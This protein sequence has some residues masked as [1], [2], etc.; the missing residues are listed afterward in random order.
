MDTPVTQAPVQ[1]AVVVLPPFN[2]RTLTDVVLDHPPPGAW[3]KFLQ[4]K[5]DRVRWA[6]IK[7]NE[8][9]PYYYPAPCDVFNAF[10][11]TPLETTRVVIIGQDPYHSPRSRYDVTR[12]R[13]GLA[14]GLSFSVPRGEDLP[15]SLVNIYKELHSDLGIKPA[16]HG[17]LTA[18]ASQGVLL[19]NT[20]LTVEPGEADSH[21]ELWAPVIRPALELLAVN[22]PK[23]LV[24]MW[25]EKA[26]KCLK[27]VGSC[28]TIESSHP[29]PLGAHRGFL[30][31]KPFSQI[32][33]YLESIGEPPIE[34]ELPA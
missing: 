4:E 13:K 24:V 23:A 9:C 21:K 14:M 6:E 32:N 3:G 11:Y 30:G 29:S 12:V 5:V 31:S 8:I 20:C 16:Y 25:G 27:Y 19:L 22:R 28:P 15:P 7:I 17:D 1:S 26:K 10:Y 18:W 33:T 2:V 34:W